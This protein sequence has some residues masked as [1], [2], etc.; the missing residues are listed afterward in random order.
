MKRRKVDRKLAARQRGWDQAKAAS[1]H[2]GS[3]KGW[4]KRPGSRN[5][6]KS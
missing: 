4:E 1:P 6:R 3:S 5:P 2:P